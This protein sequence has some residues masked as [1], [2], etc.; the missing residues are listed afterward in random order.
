MFGPERF[1]RTSGSPNVFDE[2]V[3]VDANDQAP[4]TLR[5][6]NG[7]ANGSNRLSS[8]SIEINGAQV[9]G[10]SDFGS[11]VPGFDRRVTLNRNSNTLRVRLTGNPGAFL[12]LSVCGN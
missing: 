11:S 12:T 1:T 6:I 9:A 5:V 10:P 2:T 7:N 3:T 8:A 4:F